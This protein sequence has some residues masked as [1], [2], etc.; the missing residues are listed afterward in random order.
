MWYLGSKWRCCVND[1]SDSLKHLIV[2]GWVNY[3]WDQDNVELIAEPLEV[4]FDFLSIL[5]TRRSS[6]GQ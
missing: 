4:S 3:I 2:G 1:E 6:K 5:G